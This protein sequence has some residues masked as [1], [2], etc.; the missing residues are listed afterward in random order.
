VAP[1]EVVGYLGPNGSGKTTTIRL[2]LGLARPDAA[3]LSRGRETDLR[4]GLP[5][6]EEIDDPPA[7][8]GDRLGAG[9]A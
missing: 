2:L 5:V 7:Y 1:G 6:A 4:G 8:L 3:G 9:A